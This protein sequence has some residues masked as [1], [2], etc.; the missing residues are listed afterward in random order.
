MENNLKKVE[1]L[2]E[3][4]DNKIDYLKNNIKPTE[5]DSYV[6][7]YNITNSRIL[8]NLQQ[9]TNISKSY[10]SLIG[11]EVYK[12][13]KSYRI[14]KDIPENTNWNPVESDKIIYTQEMFY[15]FIIQ[16]LKYVKLYH[17]E[18]IL[19]VS[20]YNSTSCISN[21]K[22]LLE[23]N[24]DRDTVKLLKQYLETILNIWE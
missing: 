17:T 2:F 23:F 10:F 8:N 6:F 22:T 16:H 5:K 13:S 21:V 24:A 12:S 1:L 15:D 9:F 18:N 20:L 7:G 14:Y 19:N 11:Q 4:L 3:T